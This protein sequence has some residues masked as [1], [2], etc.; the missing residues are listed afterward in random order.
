MLKEYSRWGANEEHIRAYKALE[1]QKNNLR[2]IEEIILRQRSRAIWL[3]DRDLSIAF[4][5]EDKPKE[6]Y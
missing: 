6:K 5:W 2:R 3:K 4:S 1:Q